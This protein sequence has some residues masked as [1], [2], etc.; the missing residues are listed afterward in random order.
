MRIW[1]WFNLLDCNVYTWRQR[2]KDKTAEIIV[3]GSVEQV[4]G[5]T[6][7]REID[8]SPKIENYIEPVKEKK[9]VKRK[10]LK[11]KGVSTTVKTKAPKRKRKAK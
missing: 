9:Q 4:Q 11:K 3:K 2:L 7:E 1:G 8:L 5:E 10:P 6:V